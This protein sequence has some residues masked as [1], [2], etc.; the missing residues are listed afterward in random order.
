MRFSEIIFEQDVSSSEVIQDLVRTELNNLIQDKE[1]VL[2]YED[3]VDWVH[4][5]IDINDGLQYFRRDHIDSWLETD[6]NGWD[7]I[8]LDDET[9]MVTVKEPEEVYYDPE[10]D[11]GDDDLEGDDE[12]D[13]MGDEYTDYDPGMAGPTGGQPPEEM[14]EPVRPNPVRQMASRELQRNRRF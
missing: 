6:K 8:T 2:P 11:L 7:I 4:N 9:G 12:L 10:E 3:F 1:K 13:D 14:Q 5:V